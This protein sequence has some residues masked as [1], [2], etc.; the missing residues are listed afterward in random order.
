VQVG[1]CLP[2]FTVDGQLPLAAARDAEADGY[3][4]LCLFDHLRPL[5][6]PPARP[7][8]ECLTS[9]AAVATVTS[10]VTVAPL[11]LRASLRPAA[12]VGAAFRT[13]A[14]LAPGRL[15]C[16]IGAGDR[17]NEAEDVSVGLPVLS[18]G[19]RHAGVQSLVRAVRSAV[20][21]VPIWIGGRGRA[22]KAMAGQLADGWNV[23]GV[24]AESLRSGAAEVQAAAAESGRPAPRI[25]WAGQ[26]LLAPTA[27]EADRQVAAWGAGRSEGELAGLISGDAAGVERRLAELLTAGAQTIALSF[28]GPDAARAR[29]SFPQTVLPGVRR[30]E[31]I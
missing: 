4:M 5:G 28:V 6:G 27:Q 21:G 1:L 13:L 14:L 29:R 7:I 2:Q 8:L 18:V 20:P 12:T 25:T 16:G 9:L 19:S 3:D 22:I 11:V 23:W 26:I 10:R 15:I 31:V 30:R 24:P 17:L